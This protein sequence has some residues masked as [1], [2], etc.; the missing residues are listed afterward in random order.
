MWPTGQTGWPVY[1][2]GLNGPSLNGLAWPISWPYSQL[3]FFHLQKCKLETFFKE[4][5]CEPLELLHKD[6]EALQ[7]S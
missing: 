1:F 5:K 2:A 4:N 3:K 7:F 6:N